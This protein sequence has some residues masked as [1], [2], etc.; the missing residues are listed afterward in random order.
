[1]RS[2][3][4]MATGARYGCFYYGLSL[5]A[6]LITYIVS[7]CADQNTA[8]D[9]ETFNLPVARD[10]TVKIASFKEINRRSST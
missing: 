3:K 7:F 5:R 1:M 10:S 2:D 6:H 8:L 9:S 4:E